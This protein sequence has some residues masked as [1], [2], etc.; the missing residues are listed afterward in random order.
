MNQKSSLREVP[1][2]VSGALTA[3]IRKI[4]GPYSPLARFAL[5]ARIAEL[6][7][8]A[9]GTKAVIWHRENEDENMALV[10]HPN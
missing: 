5:A 8:G 10:N 4:S 1:Q 2:V 9:G 7:V 3:D 6:A